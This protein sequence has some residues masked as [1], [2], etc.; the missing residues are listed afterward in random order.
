MAEK[1]KSWAE[2][3]REGTPSPKPPESHLAV[4]NWFRVVGAL[5]DKA[6]EHLSVK[7]TAENCE[8][9]ARILEAG[10]GMHSCSPREH[11]L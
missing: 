3:I 10:I 5:D 1:S 8:E 2:R 7:L 4:A 9:V 11:E 6:R